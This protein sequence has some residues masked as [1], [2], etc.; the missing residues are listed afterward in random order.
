MSEQLERTP[1]KAGAKEIL[2]RELAEKIVKLVSQFPD[3]GIDV[4]YN[5]VIEQ[6]KRR[7]GHEFKRNVLSQKQWDGRR[8]IA[9]AV[10]DAKVARRRSLKEEAPKYADSPRSRLRKV[11]AKL[12]AENLALREQLDRIRAQQYDELHSLLDLRTPMHRLLEFRA[13]E[14]A[15]APTSTQGPSNVTPIAGRKRQ[16]AKP[17]GSA[18]P[19]GRGKR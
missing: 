10:D 2:T 12:Q 17:S 8:L 6:V 11:I 15:G 13:A 1:G 16:P 5:N 3:A 9:E 19:Q 18:K 4:T 14:D 7:F